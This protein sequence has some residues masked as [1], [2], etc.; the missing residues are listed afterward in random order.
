MARSRSSRGK[1]APAAGG[2][3]AFTSYPV[4]RPLQARLISLEKRIGLFSEEQSFAADSRF[5]HPVILPAAE[6]IPGT[7]AVIFSEDLAALARLREPP[8]TC[9]CTDVGSYR[10]YCL[11]YFHYDGFKALMYV[12]REG[13]F[14]AAWKEEEVL[15]P[16]SPHTLLAGVDER[17]I[18]TFL[19]QVQSG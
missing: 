17:Q 8:A 3:G 5:N 9:H 18:E 14:V 4:G 16:D 19:Q 11:S 7:M 1:G 10:V 2:R 12:E 6:P 13:R 15:R